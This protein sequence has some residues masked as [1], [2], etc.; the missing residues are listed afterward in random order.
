MDLATSIRFDLQV[1]QMILEHYILE[2]ERRDSVTSDGPF[3]FEID[4]SVLMILGRP[5]KLWYNL[6]F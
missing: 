5:V 4:N 1:T 2:Q 6:T 3:N